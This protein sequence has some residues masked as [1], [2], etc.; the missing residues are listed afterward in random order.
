VR[1]GWE[2]ES[3]V[4]RVIHRQELCRVAAAPL[5]RFGSP[6][7]RHLV[8]M[9]RCRSYGPVLGGIAVQVAE[10]DSGELAVNT[11]IRGFAGREQR[12]DDRGSGAIFEANQGNR[13]VFGGRCPGLA[14]CDSRDFFPR[15]EQVQ[16]EVELVDAVAHGWTAA[17]RLP[18]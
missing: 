9:A 7:G 17:F 8:L 18:G 3:G 10:L 13:E 12:V 5:Q 16:E 1:S 6:S 15:A 4:E 14:G 2:R 11:D